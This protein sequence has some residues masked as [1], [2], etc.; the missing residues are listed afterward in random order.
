MIDKYIVRSIINMFIFLEFSDDALVNEDA[1][2]SQMEALACELQC[3]ALETRI[4]LSAQMRELST[5][6]GE[7]SDFVRNLPQAVGLE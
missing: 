2:V 6:Y 5:E 1:A 3:A 7:R 4:H